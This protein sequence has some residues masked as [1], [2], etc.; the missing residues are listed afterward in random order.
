MSMIRLY[1][2]EELNTESTSI[3]YIDVD[4]EDC[5]FFD[6]NVVF[7]QHVDGVWYTKFSDAKQAAIN[8][9]KDKVAGY[10][11]ALKRVRSLKKSDTFS[12]K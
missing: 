10:R 3:L 4:K 1:G 12:A 7:V 6:D 8:D 2:W 9:L 11:N 5:T